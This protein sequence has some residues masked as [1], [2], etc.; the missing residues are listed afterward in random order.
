MTSAYAHIEA[1]LAPIAVA[2]L[3][4]AS[5][6][7][8]LDPDRLP[9]GA[10]LFLVSELAARGN[11]YWNGTRRRYTITWGGRRLLARLNRAAPLNPALPDKP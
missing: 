9:Y 10:N 6:P 1:A 2:L 3:V 4:D 7:T 5:L 11:L 8:G